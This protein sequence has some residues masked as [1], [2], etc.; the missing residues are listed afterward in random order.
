M[1]LLVGLLGLLLLVLLAL[2]VLVVA[3]V[4]T[5]P[6]LGVGAL[7]GPVQVRDR[8]PEQV[9][10]GVPAAQWPLIQ[11]AAQDSTCNVN[12]EDLAAIAKIESDFGHNLRN[13]RS[14]AFGY[15]Q[16]DGPTWAL[17]GAGD[18]NRPADALPTIARTLCARGYGTDRAR[19]LNSYGGCI[20]PKCLGTNDYATAVNQLAVTFARASARDVV[21][22][23]RQWLG[24][25]YVFG[26]CSRNGVDCSCL[27]QL[28]YRAVGV[29]LPRVAADQWNAVKPIARA[30]LLPG[31]LVFFANTYMP[32]VSHV[33]LYVGNGQ[34][35]NAPA[36]GQ[37]VSLQPVF[38]GFWG[39]H[40]AG[41]G[42]VPS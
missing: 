33:G 1:K 9:V 35:I 41:A 26:G 29:N 6:W 30:D 20:S 8:R 32:G 4:A 42:R 24:V 40:Y 16:F 12:A 7:V 36:E 3:V 5:H 13:P 27:V 23:A 10:A 38:D 15:G 19:A 21:D 39:A 28:V 25:P 22:I 34:Q 17:F 2:P 31:D 18:P 37:R 14:G 11:S